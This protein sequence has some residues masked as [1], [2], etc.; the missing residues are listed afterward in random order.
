MSYTIVTP[1]E[2]ATTVNLSEE[3]TVSTE[4][5]RS[6]QVDRPVT[7]SSEMDKIRQRMIAPTNKND[8]LYMLDNKVR[9]INYEQIEPFESLE[10]LLNPYQAA[11]I[12]SPNA[13]GYGTGE[14]V[15]H[16]TCLFVM[17]GTNILHY[18]DSYGNAV[19][20]PIE[21]FNKQEEQMHEQTR[22]HPK[23]LQLIES[24]PFAKKFQWNHTDF[25][26]NKIATST[27]GL[28]CVVRLKNN[29]LGDNDFTKLYLDMPLSEGILPDFSVSKVIL[30]LY[31]ELKI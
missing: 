30:D 9:V 14:E 17:P 16:W 23:L 3:P 29:H 19:D 6:V 22:I 11:I 20:E 18:F 5:P 21:R 15:G 31:P 13:E 10:Q 1:A 24:S 2:P 25:Q 27:C 12:L 8:L 4:Q 28:W 7:P 26:S